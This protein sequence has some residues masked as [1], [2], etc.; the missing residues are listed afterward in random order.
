MWRRW[1]PPVVLGLSGLALTFVGWIGLSAPAD[2]MSPLGIP[3]D[4]ASAHNEIRAAY[5]GM[6]VGLGLFLVVAALRPALRSTG[7]WVNLCI[8]GGLVA[9]RLVSFV[10]DGAPGDFVVRLLIPE[11][12]GAVLSALLLA[13]GGRARSSVGTR[14]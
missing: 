4:G 10:L 12:A 11:A 3:L 1:L 9:G 7:L 14:F 5:G 8:M 6:H 2:L 13:A